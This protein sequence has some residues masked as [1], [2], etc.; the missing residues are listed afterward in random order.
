MIC[1][2]SSPSDACLSLLLKAQKNKHSLLLPYYVHRL[3]I[4]PIQAE[5][6]S[7]QSI[8]EKQQNSFIVLQT[9]QIKSCEEKLTHCYNEHSNAVNDSDVKTVLISHPDVRQQN[10]DIPGYLFYCPNK[11]SRGEIQ[12]S[13][14]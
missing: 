2:L 9:Q 3:C 4:L 14:C 6:G 7:L 8:S 12:Q 10:P 11:L 1:D 5:T 13:T